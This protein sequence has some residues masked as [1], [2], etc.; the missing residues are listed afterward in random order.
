MKGKTQ[1]L[2]QGWRQQG[3]TLQEGKPGE[4]MMKGEPGMEEDKELDGH[5]KLGSG[6]IRSVTQGMV[7]CSLSMQ[8]WNAKIPEV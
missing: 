3:R 2:N 1:H 4:E 8:Q 6:R 7:I 5:T